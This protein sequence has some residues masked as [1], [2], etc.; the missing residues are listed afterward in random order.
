MATVCTSRAVTG[1]TGAVY[2]GGIRI[3]RV[4]SWSIEAT[5]EE[6]VFAD[7]G[8]GNG[9]FVK[10][11]LTYVN[12]LPGNLN[13]SGTVEFTYDVL[14]PQYH[15]VREGYCCALI[16]VMH[17]NTV[18]A[19][20]VPSA[21]ITR[22]MLNINVQDADPIS[23]SF[24]WGNDGFYYAPGEIGAPAVGTLAAAPVACASP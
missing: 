16:L 18:K 9:V 3:A 17:T 20:Q 12:R 24:D 15:C 2:C 13:A 8:G 4:T 6:K 19:W 22:L 7:S 10:N 14:F 23:G 5:A 21:L 1:S 11:G